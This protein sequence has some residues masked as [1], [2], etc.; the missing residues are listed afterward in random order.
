MGQVERVGAV[1]AA[2]L[3]VTSMFAPVVGGSA[4]GSTEISN[5]AATSTVDSN[6]DVSGQPALILKG[7]AV[8][9]VDKLAASKK[10]QESART[11]AFELLNGT[12]SAYRGPTRIESRSVLEDDADAVRALSAYAETSQQ[13]NASRAS[14]LVLAADNASA[15]QK[16]ADAR[17]LLNATADDI[18]DRGE[19][20]SM[21][22]HLENAER[23]YERA[24]AAMAEAE[25][26]T[27]NRRSSSAPGPSNIY[28]RPGTRRSTSSS[29][30]TSIRRPRCGL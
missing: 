25:N 1:V 2:L 14:R 5:E 16:L 7:R 21:E 6:V 26:A 4:T 9:T 12:L 17:Y 11:R 3:M 28:A 18:D 24:E 10:R 15:Y 19:R 8:N 13:A 22:A 20:R 27:G 30:P 23:A 29:A